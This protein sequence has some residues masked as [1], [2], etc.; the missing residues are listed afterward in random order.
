[1]FKRRINAESN[2]SIAR[3]NLQALS[4]DVGVDPAEALEKDIFLHGQARVDLCRVGLLGLH[5]VTGEN[6]ARNMTGEP[7]HAMKTWKSNELQQRCC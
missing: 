1:M 4:Q 7:V 5:S 6:P 3:P 2:E